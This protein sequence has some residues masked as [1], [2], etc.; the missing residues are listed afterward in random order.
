MPP[1]ASFELRVEIG[2]LCLFACDPKRPKI[3]VLMPDA[4]LTNAPLRTLDK[5]PAKAHAGYLRFDL[6]NLDSG[7]SGTVVAPNSD[8]TPN[9]EVVHLLDREE[10]QFGLD[11]DSGKLEN[12]LSIPDFNEFAGAL[13]LNPACLATVPPKAV[14]ARTFL[15]GGIVET[16]SI[17]TRMWD[18][19]PLGSPKAIKKQYGSQ[20]WWRRTVQG[21]GLTLRLVKFDGSGVV[22]VPLKPTKVGK[23]VPAI[24]LKLSNL[25]SKN[26]L[27]W[28][29]LE[30]NLIA[31]P[32][33]DF[34]W[35]YNLL[36]KK[37]GSK[38]A[39]PPKVLPHPDPNYE[40]GE[41]QLQDCFPG[42]IQT[43]L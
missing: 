20:T 26:P 37:A 31:E 41:G 29:S 38:I 18:I 40:V 5:M 15:R 12:K 42:T 17:Q 27:E 28:D 30:E 22:E 21:H 24:T 3:A 2:G 11:G 23:D 16:M 8:S 14:L 9:F 13:E 10:V 1:A 36:R 33:V 6:A 35:L 39:F 34:K 32:D 19:A 25:C 7:A 43:S 4:R